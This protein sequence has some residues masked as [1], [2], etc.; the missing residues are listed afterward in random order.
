[1]RK[2]LIF[3]RGDRLQTYAFCITPAPFVFGYTCCPSL[4]AVAVIEIVMPIPMVSHG[5]PSQFAETLH[6]CLY[7]RDH[8]FTEGSDESVDATR[9]ICITTRP[10][11]STFA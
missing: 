6:S 1:M 8:E 3:P 11:S 10:G 9:R 4:T 7:A 2:P 5:L